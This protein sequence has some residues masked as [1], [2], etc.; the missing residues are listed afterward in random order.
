[1]LRAM[2]QNMCRDGRALFG[3]FSVFVLVFFLSGCGGV[4]QRALVWTDVPELVIAAQLFNRENTQ[5]AVDIEYKANAASEMK[6]TNSPPSV[7]VAKYLLSKPLTKKFISLNDLFSKYYLDPNDM[8][9]ALLDAGKQGTDYLLMPLSFDCMVLVGRRAEHTSAGVAVLSSDML[10]VSS[11]AFTKIDG[12]KVS[13]MGFSPRWN[14]EF[15]E[16]WLLAG[17]AEFS[18]NQNWKSISV[19]RPEEGSSWPIL[20][21]KAKLEESVDALVSLCS[22]VKKEQ[23]DAFTFTYFNKPGYQLVLENRVLY[24][25]MRASEFFKLPYSAKNQLQYRFPVVNKKILLTADTRYIGIP[26]GARSKKAAFAF[27]R[28]LLIAENQK[29]VWQ[30]MESQQLLPDYIPFGGFS[31]IVQMNERMYTKYFPEY[32]QTPLVSSSLP[33]PAA[34]PDYWDS[35]SRHF[36]YHWLTDALATPLT[37]GAVDESFRA[38]LEQYVGTMP[39]WLSTDR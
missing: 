6:K 15:A 18:L 14:V 21:N 26:K 33:S 8:Y 30:E 19:A 10:Q 34:L 28:W 12:E 35:F 9:P 7:V 32:A 31:S 2:K 27:V 29:K 4:P 3:S 16:D 20:W 24:W 37:R 36:L 5:F 11:K 23:E 13:A 38:S 1:M 17:G 22:D 25:P 39:D